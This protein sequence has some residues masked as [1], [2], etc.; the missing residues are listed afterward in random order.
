MNV[1]IRRITSNRRVLQTINSSLRFPSIQWYYQP[2]S[3]VLNSRS[4]TNTPTT[5]DLQFN[6]DSLCDGGSKLTETAS[7]PSHWRH[8]TLANLSL[9]LEY[10]KFE[11]KSQSEA[12]SDEV[13]RMMRARGIVNQSLLGITKKDFSLKEIEEAMEVMRLLKDRGIYANF[14]KGVA[15]LQAEISYP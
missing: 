13:E 9:V 8:F 14:H 5:K 7:Q 2:C 12:T 6:Q 3:E 11:V 4:V 15:T 10:L 1:L